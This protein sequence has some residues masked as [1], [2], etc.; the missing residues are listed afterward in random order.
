M[1]KLICLA[2]AVLLTLGMLPTASAAQL[3][4]S[5]VKQ[6][7]WYA[8]AVEYVYT[9]GLM[10]G[11]GNNLFSPDTNMSRGMIVTVLHRLEG[12]PEPTVTMPF[13]D[14]SV[15][16]YYYNVYVQH[17]GRKFGY[18]PMWWNEADSRPDVGV[19]IDDPDLRTKV[20]E[21]TGDTTS[22]F[23]VIK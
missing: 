12:S 16:A 11:M 21:I 9:N 1:K 13:G 19:Y 14:V 7:S 5:D 20:A 10:N 18:F 22:Q 15:N 23:Y 3:P 6:E 2:L 8:D 17:S 4:F